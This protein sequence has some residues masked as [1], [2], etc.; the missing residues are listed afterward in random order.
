M[1]S[2][3]T[4]SA[5][6]V[7]AGLSAGC[8]ELLPKAQ[9][10]VRSAWSTFEEARDAI[11]RIE[12]G[13]TTTAELR[14][15]GIDPYVSPNIQLLTFSDISLR[16]PVNMSHDRLDPGLRECLEAGKECTGYSISVRDV[17]RDRVG[18]FWEDALKFKRTVLVTGWTFNALLLLVDDRVVYSLYGGQ[19]QMLEQEITR[20]PLGP[21]QDFGD[22]LPLGNL[23]R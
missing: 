3:R 15:K 4:A 2:L 23:I 16:F 22:S 9:S 10:E 11:E 13:K 7:A 14:A 18:G 17:K 1:H 21:V 8:A 6:I 12:A 19:P 5:L 20:Q